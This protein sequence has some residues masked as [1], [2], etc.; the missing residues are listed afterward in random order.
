MLLHNHLT[1]PDY[2]KGTKAD[3]QRE[4]VD[5][6]CAMLW[7]LS[8]EVLKLQ[9]HAAKSNFTGDIVADEKT[10]M[11]MDALAK[12]QQTHSGKQRKGILRWL[13]KK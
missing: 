2:S 13:K 5:R 12:M 10:A 11:R 1:H 4:L 7:D 9:L 3:L 6:I 8:T